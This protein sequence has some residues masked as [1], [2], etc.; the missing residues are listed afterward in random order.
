MTPSDVLKFAS[1]HGAKMLDL[2]FLDLP[3]LWQHLTVPI[4]ELREEVFTE[5]IGF[6]GSSIR[7]WQAINASDMLVIPDP[8]TARMDPFTKEPTLVM[9]CDIVD[10]VTRENYSRDPRHIAKKAE[11]YMRATGIADTAY[12]GARGR[13]LHL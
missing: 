12:F 11:A 13:V 2:R 1:E 7:G 3:G 5:G 10:P 6:D 9:I 4:S 8:N